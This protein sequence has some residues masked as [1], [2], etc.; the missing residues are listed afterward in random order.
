M[1]VLMVISIQLKL[2]VWEN[3]GFEVKTKNGLGQSELSIL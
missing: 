3:S 1:E 2:H